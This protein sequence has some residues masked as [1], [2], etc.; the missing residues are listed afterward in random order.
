MLF[1]MHSTRP[2]VSSTRRHR[3]SVPQPDSLIG[4]ERRDKK[5]GST[6][7]RALGLGRECSLSWYRCRI[8]FPCASQEGT[9]TSAARN[10][11][12]AAV[13]LRPPA[14]RASGRKWLHRSH[15]AHISG[16][17]TLRRKAELA[18]RH[19]GRKASAHA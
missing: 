12:V 6:P 11:T 13:Q 3:S 16:G 18:A 2:A 1:V 5:R 17:V 4:S 7:S 10:V 14:A 19:N 15:P 9:R 8:P